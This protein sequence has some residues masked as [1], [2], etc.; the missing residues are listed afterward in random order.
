MTE[1]TPVSQNEEILAE[2]YQLRL[3]QVIRM[4]GPGIFQSR[5]RLVED[6][7]RMLPKNR[8]ENHW[9]L[10]ALEANVFGILR[11]TPLEK[12][13]EVYARLIYILVKDH[14]LNHKAAR[15]CVDTFCHF[16]G[17]EITVPERTI[18]WLEQTLSP[19][20]KQEA[21][22]QKMGK[23][24]S[25]L[26]FIMPVFLIGISLGSGIRWFKNKEVIN[27]IP[28]NHSQIPAQSAPQAIR[29]HNI[30]VLREALLSGYPV[31][32]RDSLG[33]T[34]LMHAAQAGFEEGIRLLLENKADIN[35]I[36]SE[37]RT[38]LILAS[39]QGQIEIVRLLCAFDANV[40][41]KDNSGRT[42]LIHAIFKQH[43]SVVQFL[44]F[45]EKSQSSFE[46]ETG[47]PSP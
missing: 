46:Y 26:A 10:I 47:K 28:Q 2:D 13:G 32:Q 34:P 15:F 36:D 42:A 3:K 4:Q 39:I 8:R 18:Q 40:Y 44:A 16:L 20:P 9:M 12:L 17:H 27:T 22:Q 24:A 29:G 1:V 19:P 31:N 6:L 38:A 43:N 37:G 14:G 41:H 21:P 23:L 30:S 33:Q 25:A 35:A 5:T 45:T 11:V 7:N